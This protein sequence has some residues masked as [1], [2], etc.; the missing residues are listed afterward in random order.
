MPRYEVLSPLRFDGE[1]FEPGD[2]VEM[3]AKAAAELVTRNV[4]ARA[5]AQA[6]VKPGQKGGGNTE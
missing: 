2:T 4:L 6:P 1:A 3:T 5:K